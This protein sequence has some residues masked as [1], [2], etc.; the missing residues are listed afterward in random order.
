MAKKKSRVVRRN[1]QQRQNKA[2]S[3]NKW[4]A[5]L[6]AVVVVAVLLTAGG[7]NYFMDEHAPAAEQNQIASTD[8]PR[9][10]KEIRPTL[11]PDL[12]SG[13]VRKAYIIAREIPEVLDQLYCYCRC[14]E[15]F[16]H[17]NLLTCYTNDHAS[18]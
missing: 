2:R 8:T 4:S 17:L 14:R 5:V 12:F 1:Q 9:G 6:P 13:T 3:K 15:N 18:T 7:I 11:S 10:L 16:N